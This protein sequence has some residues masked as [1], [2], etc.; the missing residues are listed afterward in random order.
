MFILTPLFCVCAL[1][2]FVYVDFSV[3]A[4]GAH[5]RSCK[6]AMNCKLFYSIVIAPTRALHKFVQCPRSI[7]LLVSSGAFARQRINTT[8]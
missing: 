3:V 5:V 4:V 7:S 8:I 1:C 2:V 6:R